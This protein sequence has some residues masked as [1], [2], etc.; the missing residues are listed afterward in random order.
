MSSFANTPRKLLFALRHAP[1]G[2]TFAKESLDAIL[3]TAVYEQ[4]LS[5]VFMDDGVFQLI[6]S[7]QADAINE[8]SFS[9]MLSAFPLYDIDRVFVCE[10]SLVERGISL[11]SI[12]TIVQPLNTQALNQLFQ[13]QD[14]LLSF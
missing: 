2:N 3:A 1:Y 13:Q 9:N 4:T 11:Q 7:Q 12:P 6:N 8:K 10:Q 5:V 14:H